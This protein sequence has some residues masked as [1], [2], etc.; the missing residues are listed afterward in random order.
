MIELTHETIRH[1]FDYK[2]GHLIWKNPPH[3]KGPARPGMVA[4]C[5]DVLGYWRIGISG[6]R[7][8]AHRLIWLWHHGEMPKVI[9]HI[10]NDKGDNRIEN[11]RVCTRSQ[12]QM[13]VPLLNCNTSGIKGVGW[14]KHMNKWRAFVG[15]LGRSKH[16]GYYDTKEEA[17]EA[18]KA[19]RLQLH[20][21]FA[22]FG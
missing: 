5:R 11:L 22:H 3:K 14:A 10:N 4:G 15:I 8:Y 2:D 19:V 21:E 12:N 9:D 1:I 20:K 18:A 7:E 16:I 6:R 13:N 17:A